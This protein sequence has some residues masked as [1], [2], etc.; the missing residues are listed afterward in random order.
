MFRIILPIFILLICVHNHTLQAQTS[1]SAVMRTEMRAQVNGNG[2]VLLRW[3]PVDYPSFWWARNHGY[4]LSRSKV[5]VNGQP[6]STVQASAMEILVENIKPWSETAFQNL[7]NSDSSDWPDLGAA[8]IYGEGFSIINPGNASVMEIIDASKEQQNRFSFGLFAAEQSY[9]VARAMGLGFIDYTAAANTQYVYLLEIR[10]TTYKVAKRCYLSVNTA[11]TVT[12]PTPRLS[13]E[14]KDKAVLLRWELDNLEAHYSSYA[15]ERSANNGV[16]WTKQNTRPFVSISNDNAPI[17]AF[18]YLDSLVSNT[19]NYKYR[20]QGRTSFGIPGPFSNVVTSKGVQSPVD[21]IG[22]TVKVVEAIQGQMKV[23]WEVAAGSVGKI[24]KFDVFRAED[25]SKPYIKINPSVLDSTKREFIDLTPNATNFYRIESTDIYGFKHQ[26]I[27][28][29]GQPIDA[30]PPAAPPTPV[31][32]C[33]K[34]GR[35][36]IDWSPSISNDVMGYRVFMSNNNNKSDMKQITPDWVKASEFDYTITMQTLSEQVFFCVKAIDFRENSSAFSAPCT[37]QRPDII[38]PAAPVIKNYQLIGDDVLLNFIAS[39]SE[40]VVSYSVERRVKGYVD[41]QVLKSFPPAEI[42][43][44]YT[45]TSAFKR[46]RYE[47]RLVAHDDVQLI[48]PSNILEIKPMDDG[49]RASIQNLIATKIGVQ[50]PSPGLPKAVLLTWDYTSVQDKDFMGFQIMRAVGGDVPYNLIFLPEKD[51]R[52]SGLII[53]DAS[54]SI[55]AMFGFLDYDVFNFKSLLQQGLVAPVTQANPPITPGSKGV[56]V[57]YTVF[58][59]YVDGAMS[60]LNSVV[61][62]W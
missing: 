21:Q 49:L 53:P 57:R 16:S 30:T 34:N 43:N 46:W 54:I 4:R 55:Q 17:E 6:D 45:D 61:V 33:D 10:D 27:A 52:Y 20:I 1:G 32:T 56:G 26:S 42:N 18:F 15:V 2:A 11:T 22:V 8:A 25:V 29:M 51:A 12:L 50:L 60:P 7:M 62:S 19:V 38:P 47:Y 58:A 3:A 40:D 13:S 31:C 44:A 5:K 36:H 39:S 9:D 14:G 23:N 48:T 37:A 35:V 28:A 59:K 24:S 41:W